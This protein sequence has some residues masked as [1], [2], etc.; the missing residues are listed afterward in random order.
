MDNIPEWFLNLPDGGNIIAY[1]AGT[2][3]NLK[4]QTA[5]DRALGEARETLAS[6]LNLTITQQLNKIVDEIS[7]GN[8]ITLTEQLTEVTNYTTN[9]VKVSGWKEVEKDIQKNGDNYLVYVL[10]QF[11]LRD[12]NKILL[13]QIK[14]N[15][16]SFQ[17]LKASQ[18]FQELEE[19]VNKSS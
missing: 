3:E 17:K 15:E 2:N 16:D 11:N 13:D 9:T 8:D 18:A 5:Y 10:I 12:A 14:T 6:S 4:L 1:A 19:E 7:A